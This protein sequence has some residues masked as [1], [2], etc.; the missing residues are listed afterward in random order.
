MCS[1]D[2]TP[3]RAS[4]P[5]DNHAALQWYA[6][7]QG[8]ADLR[9][10]FNKL[11]AIADSEVQMSRKKETQNLSMSFQRN[12]QQWQVSFPADFPSTNASVF[13]N[14]EVYAVAGGDTVRSAVRAIISKIKHTPAVGIHGN[15]ADQWYGGEQGEAILRYVFNELT[16]IADSEV[17]MSRKTDTQD[18]TLSLERSGHHW[19]V[20]FPSNFPR[21][22]ASLFINREFIAVVGGDT[23][24]TAVRAII[25]RIS[26]LDPS[27]IN[28]GNPTCQQPAVQW[29]AGENGEATLK[30]VFNE[31]SKIAHGNVQMSRRTDTQDITMC[32]CRQ[33]Q[34]WQVTFPSNFPSSEASLSI[35]KRVCTTIGGDNVEH[36]VCATINYITST[37]QPPRPVFVRR[38]QPVCSIT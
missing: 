31:L 12:G 15:S 23:V 7:D 13:T 38:M 14:G 17:K 22:D 28:R 1:T 2:V 27:F 36:A 10:I 3:L 9:Y 30:Y 26:S 29:Y 20:K 5:C 34:E 35:N 8:E 6:S 18:L 19:Q 21:S 32:F 25:H 33:G 37:D 16:N 24:E 4:P 11:K